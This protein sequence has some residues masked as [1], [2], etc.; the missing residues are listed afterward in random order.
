MKY[1]QAKVCILTTNETMGLQEFLDE[2]RREWR[3]ECLS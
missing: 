1:N 3:A 2:K